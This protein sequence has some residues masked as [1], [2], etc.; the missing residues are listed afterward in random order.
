MASGGDCVGLQHWECPSPSLRDHL[1]SR[2][3]FITSNILLTTFSTHSVQTHTCFAP[4]LCMSLLTPKVFSLPML[5]NNT[6]LVSLQPSCFFF[7]PPKHVP[8]HSSMELLSSCLKAF[9]NMII[10]TMM[11]Y[12]DKHQVMFKNICNFPNFSP[13]PLQELVSSHPFCYT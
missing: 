2:T 9:N 8:R 3:G 7:F 13:F 6:W 4:Q 11:A 1:V 12:W 5:K 10:N